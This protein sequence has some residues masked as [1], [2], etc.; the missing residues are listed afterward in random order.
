MA[1]PSRFHYPQEAESDASDSDSDCSSDSS[2]DLDDVCAH[3]GESLSCREQPVGPRLTR[4]AG[5]CSTGSQEEE[6]VLAAAHQQRLIAAAAILLL[7]QEGESFEKRIPPFSWAEHVARLTEGEFKLR[8][9]VT[10]DSFYKLLEIL[11]PMLDVTSQRHA[12]SSRAGKPIELETRLA[13]AL[14]YFAGGH[15]LDL[16]LIYG[17]SKQQVMNCVWRAVDA[18]NH[19]L[20]NM[21]F[22]IDDIGKLQEL[23]RDFR[24]GTRGDFWR[25]QVGAI[26]GV[27]FRMK[28]PSKRAV[29]DPMRYYVQ[30]KQE[31]A[32]LAMAICD[33]HRR[34]TWVDISHASCTHDSTAWAATELGQRVAQGELPEPFFLNG[35]AAFPLGPSMITPSTGDPE[36]DNFDFYQSSNRMAIECAFGILV[37]RWGVLWRT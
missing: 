30:R 1:G 8:Y 27:H 13:C 2:D 3:L 29:K 20:D 23:E 22:P 35:D 18:I 15:P 17:M 37:R 34:F 11:R 33:Y 5:V 9:R 21:H 12:F 19:C 25:G 4:G 6:I 31:Y 28:C 7:S 14:R 26:D 24:A 32:L 10:A 36:L 16:K